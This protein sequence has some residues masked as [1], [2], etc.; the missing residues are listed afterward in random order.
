MAAVL[1]LDSIYILG[2]NLDVMRLPRRGLE[3]LGERE[4]RSSKCRDRQKT[5]A[6]VFLVYVRR[7]R[8]EQADK[9][10]MGNL[11]YTVTFYPQA[12]LVHINLAPL[13]VTLVHKDGQSTAGHGEPNFGDS[14]A[15]VPEISEALEPLRRQARNLRMTMLG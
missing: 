2:L 11:Q 7:R 4:K 13:V 12:C 6:Y 1:A 10:G 14:L 8:K 15:M 3:I 9:M 5:D